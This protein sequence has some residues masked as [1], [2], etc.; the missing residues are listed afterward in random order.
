MLFCVSSLELFTTDLSISAVTSHT[1]TFTSAVCY[2]IACNSSTSF[3]VG[4]PLIWFSFS[5]LIRNCN[6]VKN[7]VDKHE[8][9][10]KGSDSLSAFVNIHIFVLI[11]STI[12]SLVI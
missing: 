3:P 5:Y 8:V 2:V 6:I 7:F 11:S 4:L 12:D 10:V 9:A 1:A